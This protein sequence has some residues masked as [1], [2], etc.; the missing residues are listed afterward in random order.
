MRIDRFDKDRPGLCA[1]GRRDT[2]MFYGR[3]GAAGILGDESGQAV[4]MAAMG[5][6]L[7]MGGMALAIDVG[8]VHYRQRQLQTAADSAAI[9][10]GLEIGNCNNTACTN[11]N[12]AAEKALIED[13]ITAATITPTDNQC[14]VS[15]SSGLAMIIN[16]GPCVLGS[17]DPN[18][19]NA[20]MAEVVLTQPQKTLFLSLFG[21]PTMNLVAR[22]EAGEAYI[23]SAPSGGNCIYTR[24]LEFNS[25]D[26][27]FTLNNCGIYDNGNLQ[28]DNGDS[29]T[30]AS[31][32]YY[33]T[34]S[35]NNCNNSCT[36]SLGDSETQPAHTTTAQTDPL[37]S[38]TAPTQPANSQT[39]NNTT[40]NSGT[41]LQPG[42]YPNGV[43]L[44]S[45]VSVT[46]APGLYYMNGSFNV[47]S[48]ATLTGSGVEMYFAN[49]TLQLNSGSTAQ[50]TA[51]TSSSS[52]LGTTA[53]MLVWQ[54]STN[55]NGMDIDSGSSSYF[56]GI[57]YLPNATLT[58]NSGA[59][60]TMN[61]AATY[62]DVDVNGLIVNSGE[63]FVING[64]GG[65]LGSGGSS[66][67]TL[68]TFA[69]AE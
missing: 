30:A 55:S 59:G 53:G 65:Y 21:I 61:S 40:P 66:A 63:N 58:L 18:N 56:T 3:T 26:G 49:G 17:G 67:P 45:N 5:L 35:P 68:G 11:M 46:L 27:T 28:T 12:T 50:L 43:N 64:S 54:A 29:V 34:W 51:P 1:V 62:T 22:A 8:N 39:Y 19:G 42:Y 37:A 60:V 41:T 31:F 44:N 25:S 10:A 47:D 7:L 48:G 6:S 24:S 16:V 52:T 13:G 33:G 15:N 14:T 2:Q 9:A 38:L 36:W 57:I 32:L 69:V 23:A 20:N 4:V